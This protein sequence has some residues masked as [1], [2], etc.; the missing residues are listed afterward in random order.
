MYLNRPPTGGRSPGYP[1]LV[2]FNP[3]VAGQTTGE[4]AGVNFDRRIQFEHNSKHWYGDM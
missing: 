3:D 4:H 1:A 2:I